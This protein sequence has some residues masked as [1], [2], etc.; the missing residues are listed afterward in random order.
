MTR[1][2]WCLLFADWLQENGDEPR[3]EFIRVQIELA[4]ATG[5][6]ET[7]LITRQ[8]ELLT[9]WGEVWLE[10]FRDYKSLPGRGEW[11]E[12]SRGFVERLAVDEDQEK[13]FYAAKPPIYSRTPLRALWLTNQQDYGPVT[14]W[15][16]LSRLSELEFQGSVLAADTG[17]GKLFRS[18]RVAS[19][20]TLKLIGYDDNGHLDLP[21]VIELSGRTGFREL[22]YLDLSCN[23][24]S[25]QFGDQEWVR[26]LSRSK[27]LSQLDRL[28][29]HGTLLTA[30]GV[31]HLVG[32]EWLSNLGHLDLSANDIG[33]RGARA[34]VASPHLE[35]LQ[36]LDLTE[37]FREPHHEPI[38]PAIR[39]AL[40][41]RFGPRVRLDPIP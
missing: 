21:A 12:F 5:E 40:T 31:E 4:R 27:L 8:Q 13:D 32:S 3:A 29:L 7:R 10:P 11:W 26:V 18:T 38:E 37:C 1:R 2:G 24:A 20:R 23:W 15:V 19:L 17:I 14:R 36:V 35:N 9:T 25:W 34:L 30:E 16:G 39:T 28:D 22:T 41:N 33:E 6:R